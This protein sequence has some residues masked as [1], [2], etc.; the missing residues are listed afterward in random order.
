[1]DKCRE[2]FEKW[3]E[4]QEMDIA[5]WTIWQ[6]AWNACQPKVVAPALTVGYSREQVDQIVEEL[7]SHVVDQEGTE[8]DMRDVY[9][10]ALATLTPAAQ[11]R[12]PA[13][14]V[15]ALEHYAKLRMYGEDGGLAREAL[16]KWKGGLN[17]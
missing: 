3:R 7:I 5:W 10:D 2:E 12:D 6:A 8:F 16:D 11:P 1:M 4:L 13:V 17:E 14:L 9:E 15:E